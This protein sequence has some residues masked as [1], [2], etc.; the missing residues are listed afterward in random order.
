[1]AGT[2]T[3]KRKQSSF[4]SQVL[5]YGSGLALNYGIGF[6]LLPIYSRLMPTDQ[7]GTLEILN[8]T[9]EVVSLLL[10]TQYGITYIRFYRDQTEPEYQKRVTGTSIYV[11]V[12]IAA[13]VALALVLLQKPLAGLL[14][15]SAASSH[16]IALAG[17]RYLLEMAFVVPFLYFQA[18]EQPGKYVAISATRLALTLSLN[19]LFLTM[20]DDKV[21]AVLW[22]QI[23]SAGVFVLSVGVAVFWRSVRR[24]HWPLAKEILKFTWSFSILGLFTFIIFSGDRFVI[25]EYC[26]SG[27][28]GIYS[29]GYRIAQI[30]SVLIFSPVLRA[31]SPR[32]VDTLRSPEGPRQLAQLTTFTMVAYAACGVV[33]SVYARELVG[34]IVGP[35]YFACYTIVPILVL[36]HGFQGFGSLVDG[37]IYYSKKTYI[38]NWHALTTAVSIAFYFL[39]IPHFCKLGAAWASTLGFLFLAVLNWYLSIRVYPMKFELGKLARLTLLSVVVYL[40]AYGIESYEATHLA[41]SS[42]ALK[43]ISPWLYLLTIGLVKLLLLPAF[44]GGVFA[45]R[46][47]G[48]E[49][50]Q[51]LRRM[52]D[53]LLRKRPAKPEPTT[54]SD[55][56]IGY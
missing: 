31:W 50:W 17:L 24:I 56:D 22:A 29:A 13:V 3:G 41:L 51:R 45:L 37:G 47:L 28:V 39:L 11:V 42:V 53:E 38:K 32:I 52:A 40:A 16:Y 48:A 8:R 5:V 49:D 14:F 46:I 10:L 26:G 4:L 9:I 2:T 21:A 1:M 55:P 12:G 34:I 43:L 54:T 44:V 19:I 23:V 20:M 6:I 30:L 36:G 35:T 15:D 33:F 18:T 27:E 25:N 7:Y